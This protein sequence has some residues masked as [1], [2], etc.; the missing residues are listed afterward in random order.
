MFNSRVSFT[1]SACESSSMGIVGLSEEIVD[2]DVVI[3]SQLD[4]NF[5]GKLLRS[6]FQIAVFPL[7]D[8][9]GIGYLLLRK[10]MVLS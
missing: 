4:E 3:I 9:D 2:T 8:A 7:C 1:Y 6:G 5:C 10:V